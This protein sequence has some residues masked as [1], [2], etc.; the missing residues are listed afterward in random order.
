MVVAERFHGPELRRAHPGGILSEVPVG[1]GIR[2]A[3]LGEERG[4]KE[5]R[6]GENDNAEE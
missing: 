3:D 4:R 5:Q 1:K 2:D 6:G